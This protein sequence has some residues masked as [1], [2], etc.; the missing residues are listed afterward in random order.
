M[1]F[2][3]MAEGLFYFSPKITNNINAG[4]ATLTLRG[5]N[6]YTGSVD[7]N[8]TINPCDISSA[9]VSLGSEHI[10]TG[11]AVTPAPTVVLGTTTLV[12]GTDYIVEYSSNVQVGTA[13][14]TITGKGNYIGTIES[15]FSIVEP[16]VVTPEVTPTVTPTVVPTTAPTAKPTAVPTVK[17]TFPEGFTLLQIAER[18]EENGVCSAA[19]FIEAC[20]NIKMLLYGFIYYMFYEVH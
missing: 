14:I 15:T 11:S 3:R 16:P 7:V 9:T 5:I 2:R 4:T 13:T 20:K 1:S 6:N 12:S 18:L 8:Y 19:D 10:Y 17:V